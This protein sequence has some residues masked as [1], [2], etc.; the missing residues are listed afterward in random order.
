MTPSIRKSASYAAAAA[1][2]SLFSAVATAATK[3]DAD[4]PK[5]D[6]LPSPSFGGVKGEGW[7]PKDW[8]KV[9]ARIKVAMAPEPKTK[10][11]DALTVKWYVAVDNPEKAG[12]YL[13]LVKEIQH[14]NIPLTQDVYV[15][16]FLS[17]ASIRRLTG[18]DKAGKSSVK[19]VGFEVLAD[20]A[21]VA[22]ETSGGQ[23][24]WWS[25]PSEKISESSTVPLLSKAETPFAACWWDRYAEEK[26]LSA[27]TR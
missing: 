21:V 17:P 2:F 27:T 4:K 12:T 11:C 16:V 26:S 5:F 20:G 8:L 22:S 7:S 6:D 13:K 15:C 18:S 25:V 23:K 1:I 3:V 19:F 9:E 10:T 24:G 14:V